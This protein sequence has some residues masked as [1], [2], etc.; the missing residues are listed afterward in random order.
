MQG[1]KVLYEDLLSGDS[2]PMVA[3]GHIRSPRLS[4]MRPTS[5][6]GWARYNSYITVL[7]MSKQ[8]ILLLASD[9]N[10]ESEVFDIVIGNESLRGLFHEALEFFMDETIEYDEAY[11]LFAVCDKPINDE[12]KNVVGIITSGNFDSVRN[13]ILTANYVPTS[14]ADVGVIH[15]SKASE[16]LWNKA[17]EY[18]ANQ[19]GQQES[20]VCTVGNM[21]SKLCAIHPSLNFTNVND[22]T[23]FQFYDTFFQICYMR[24]KDFE[25]QIVS[26]HGSKEFRFD[27]WMKPVKNY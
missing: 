20:E 12:E 6:I 9:A 10:P 1:A 13:L 26:N 27:D 2:I 5:G 3:I 21:L 19:G 4:E 22:L 23:V 18:L 15:N 25:E 8:Q 7:K 16:D 17:Q 14:S 24:S 11:H